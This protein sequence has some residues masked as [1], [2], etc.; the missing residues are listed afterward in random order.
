MA[1]IVDFSHMFNRSIFMNKE[2]IIENPKMIAHLLCSMLLSVS[3]KFGASK[4]NPLVL[5]IDS[6]NNWRKEYYDANKTSFLE[7]ENLSYKGQRVKDDTIDWKEI[8]STMDTL[9]SALDKYSD[10]QILSID[11]AEADDIIA[12][13][14]KEYSKTQKVFIITSDKDLKQCIIP[15]LVEMYDPIKQIFIPELDIEKF[16]KIHCMIGDKSDNILAIKPRLGEKTAEKMYSDLDT[17][18]ATNPE[19]KKR[20]TFNNFL[21]D[22]SN[23]PVII[24]SEIKKQLENKY[25][26]F[27]AMNLLSEFQKLDLKQMSEKISK[28]KL[29][30]NEVKTEL[31]S[32]SETKKQKEEFDSSILDNF[33][34]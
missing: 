32:Y 7:Y 24:E 8:Y 16:K 11:K 10:F 19:M 14:S 33:F 13:A 17:I 6:K 31:N 20:Y 27:N 5:A 2:D 15:N 22:F 25:L 1:I 29:C 26:N 28:F 34:N 21:I 4:N 9:I 12:I 30:D 3:N 23:I 18:L